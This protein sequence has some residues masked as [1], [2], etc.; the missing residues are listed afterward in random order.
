MQLAFIVGTGR[1]GSTL[2]HEIF[3]KHADSSF[4]S[5]IEENHGRLG[6]LHRYANAMYRAEHS[7]VLG[8]LAEEFIPTEG[9]ALIDRL[10]SPIYSRPMRDLTAADATPWLEKRFRGFFEKRH[11][12]AGLPMLLH[13]Y[14]GWSRL[15]FFAE[16]FPEARFVHVVRDGR[17]VANSWLQMTWWNGYQG[18]DN[19]LWGPLTEEEEDRWAQQ[20]RSYPAL[21]ALCWER[22]ALSYRSAEA[23]RLSDRVYELKYEDFLERPGELAREMIEF[24]G[25]DWTDDFE[26]QFGTFEIR[27]SRKAAYKRDLHSEQ[28][29]Q[30]EACI[31]PTL[32]RFGYS[33]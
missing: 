21:A 29:A 8:R 13:K 6:R 12:D 31:A 16:I 19:W 26:Q 5:A 33:G 30:I 11:A 28:L 18:P 25:L 9:Y 4:I 7:P 22:L 1:C 32:E 14:T 2:L 27:S 10:V 24:M 20:D 15:G 17:A 3:A 23:E